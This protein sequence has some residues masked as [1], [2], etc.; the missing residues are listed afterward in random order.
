MLGGCV[1]IMISLGCAAETLSAMLSFCLRDTVFDITIGWRKT[2]LY[3]IFYFP[4]ANVLTYVFRRYGNDLVELD[5]QLSQFSVRKAKCF[6]C[7]ND[8]KIPATGQVLQ[9]DREL[10]EASIA[11]WHGEGKA[12]EVGLDNFDKLI[13]IDL[14]R[15]VE[16]TLGGL[17]QMPYSF[18][19]TVGIWDGLAWMD[20]S[21][22]S[23]APPWCRILISTNA[24]F[25]L[26][27]ITLAMVVWMT[28][29][30]TSPTLGQKLRCEGFRNRS[31]EFLL[32]VFATFMTYLLRRICAKTIIR[33]DLLTVLWMLAE[34]SVVVVLYGQG[35]GFFTLL[36]SQ[37]K[38]RGFGDR[39][40]RM[41]TSRA[42]ASRPSSKHRKSLE[43][44]K[45]VVSPTPAKPVESQVEMVE[46]TK[47]APASGTAASQSATPKAEESNSGLGA[48]NAAQAADEIEPLDDSK[49][50]AW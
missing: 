22:G 49:V 8:H 5:Q 28:R 38:E 27:P 40:L 1:A 4:M 26:V 23:K 45:N 15:D 21:A 46:M 31:V 44:E 32:A 34:V 11:F 50:S 19:V 24:I 16:R 3:C 9:C 35:A 48:S 33:L 12:H 18:A 39:L 6:C 37:A 42:S 36:G 7:S 29:L 25:L 43:S 13:R 20:W 17:S 10:V 30:M 47:P 41:G 14:R 2:A